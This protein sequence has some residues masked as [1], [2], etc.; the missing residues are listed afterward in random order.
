MEDDSQ[1]FT[2]KNPANIQAK[3]DD[4]LDKVFNHVKKYYDFDYHFHKT[5]TKR[6]DTDFIGLPL[7]TEIDDFELTLVHIV[8]KDEREAAARLRPPLLM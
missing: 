5:F 8:R 4:P 7:D 2:Q 6:Q 1:M 3:Q